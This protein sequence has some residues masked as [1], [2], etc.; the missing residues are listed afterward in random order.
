[1]TLQEKI[2]I[3]RLLTHI[4]FYLMLAAMT[5]NAWLQGAPGVIYFLCLFPLIIFIPGLIV[6]NTRTLIWICFVIL[7]YFATAVDNLAGPSPQVL[8]WIELS[9]TVILFNAAMMYA[10]WKQARGK[11]LQA[12]QL[13]ETTTVTA[14]SI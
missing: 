13:D 10:R 1:M 7:I 2:N 9:L 4:S 12:E 8:D 11:E 14:D 6:N 3:S 5:A